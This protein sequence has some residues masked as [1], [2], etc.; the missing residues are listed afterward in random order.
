MILTP[1]TAEIAAVSADC[2]RKNAGMEM[3]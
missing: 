3:K 1:K 2:Y